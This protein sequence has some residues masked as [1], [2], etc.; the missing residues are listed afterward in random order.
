LGV[1]GAP[2][3]IR[4]LTTKFDAGVT[5]TMKVFV[6]SLIGGFKQERAAAKRAIITLRHQAIMAEDFGAQ[7][8][9]PQVAC[10]RGL[11]EADLVVLV[12]GASYGATQPSG[13][14]AT[15]EEYREA[16]N[17]KPVVAFVQEGVERD[18]AQSD[19]VTEVQA[20]EGGL[21]RGGF[22]TPEQ[23][24]DLV[25]RAIYDVDLARAVGPVD[26]SDLIGRAKALI[27]AEDRQGSDVPTLNLAIAGGPK[28]QILRP[29]EIEAKPLADAL[30]Q[31]ALFGGASV[32]DQRLGNEIG[33]NGGCLVLRQERAAS[34]QIDQG[35]SIFMRLP[36]EDTGGSRLGGFGSMH[37]IVEEAVQARLSQ[38]LAF[39]CEILD[40][41]DSTQRLTHLAVA[42]SIANA[43]Y[44]AWRTEAQHAASPRS[45]SLG[46]LCG[47][48]RS[49]VCLVQKSSALRVGRN[50]IVE[51]LLVLIR[52]QFPTGG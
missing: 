28:Q 31:S 2:P 19:F 45:V 14:S 27:P 15:H 8:N 11:R 35:G 22:E 36:L 17:S 29:I 4:S 39:A 41:I 37:V 10:L 1:Y 25:T 12:L 33:L 7:P 50:Q 32:F 23:L 24:G 21:F 48:D 30:L 42:S 43:E 3:D 46:N 44:A 47:A 13:L 9:S 5:R 26:E 16:R 6:S 34:I 38:A 49:L 52:R 20:W 51:D 40:R 18:S